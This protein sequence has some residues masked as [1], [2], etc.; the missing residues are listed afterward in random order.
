MFK[1]K[2]FVDNSKKPRHDE[3]AEKDTRAPG[4]PRQGALLK[5]RGPHSQREDS[6][7]RITPRVSFR[8]A[9]PAGQPKN[10]K[11]LANE[12]K[13]AERSAVAA[14]DDKDRAADRRIPW[15]VKRR[16]EKRAQKALM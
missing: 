2:D 9:I 5:P 12:K 11:E 3:A 7:R 14:L 8:E 15:F 1:T 10:E 16:M 13:M 6:P 4:T